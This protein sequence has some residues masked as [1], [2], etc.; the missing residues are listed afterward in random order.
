MCVER[1]S[2]SLSRLAS[3]PTD[4]LSPTTKTVNVT[5]DPAKVTLH[6][7][8]NAVATT[9][10]VHGKRYEAGVIMTIEDLKK[11][12]KRVQTTLGKL[13]LR[14][15]EIQPPQPGEIVVLFP[16]L[17][18]Q[19][20]AND[21]IKASQIAEA[22]EKAG[23]KFS[24]LT[25]VQTSGAASNSLDADKKKATAKTAGKSKL[26]GDDMAADKADKSKSSR[27]AA[28]SAKS[29]PAGDPAARSDKS[30]EGTP[31]DAPRFQIV[32]EA[33][34]KF[35]LVDHEANV[36]KFVKEGD[37]FGDYTVKQ[38]SH[39]DGLI[40]LE[41]KETKELVRVEKEKKDKPKD[42]KKPDAKEED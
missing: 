8:V 42:G 37:E 32:A 13:K 26:G 11:E 39:D 25:G 9:D 41:H 24:G 19:A 33:N 17:A 14:V 5:Y 29:K 35:Y 18:P 20:K 6:Q 27:P 38:V 30:K 21:F 28:G 12:S 16:V 22:L 7:I 10:P 2:G 34:G 3:Q 36:K 31:D 1:L 4:G 15:T 23:V 40:V